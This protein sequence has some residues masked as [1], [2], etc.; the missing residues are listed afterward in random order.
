MQNWVTKN[1]RP[2]WLKLKEG[3]NWILNS[4][5]LTYVYDEITEQPITPSCLVIGRRLVSQ[6]LCKLDNKKNEGTLSKRARYLEKLLYHF[7]GRWKK[8]YLT[9]IREH[10][11]LKTKTPSRGTLSGDIV[12]IQQDKTPRLQW[13]MGRVTR[14]YPERD[15]I[16]HSKCRSSNIKPIETSHSC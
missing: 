2:P 8:E 5:P 12:H 1:W 4:R 16:Y 7:R 10:Q 14:L 13:R 15:G 6:P 3:R 9:G 11:K